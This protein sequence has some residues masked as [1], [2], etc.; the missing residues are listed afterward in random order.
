[1]SRSQT[2]RQIPQE[3]V[4]IIERPVVPA[5]FAS[6]WPRRGQILLGLDLAICLVCFIG[7]Y[8]FRFYLDFPRDQFAFLLVP[9]PPLTPYLKAA[10][11]W[12][13]MW[14]FLLWKD[15]SYR[16][17]L[18]FST[19]LAVQV[20]TVLI[21]GLYA[22][23]FLMAV[24]FMFRQLLLSRLVYVTVF[25]V[26]GLLLILVRV[27]FRAV[28]RSLDEQC[29]TVHRLL[30]VG[31]N[32]NAAALV[33]RLR[34][35]NRC[36]HVIGRLEWEN[37][38]R[39][40]PDDIPILG[41]SSDL[42]R[43]YDQ[44]PFDKL[45]V[46]GGGLPSEDDTASRESLIKALNF[47]EE[48][49]ISYYM[50]PDFL[51]VAVTR[52]EVGSFAGVP[53]V[54]LQDSAL[55]PVYAIF[56][57]VVDVAISLLVLVLGLPFWLA[58]ALLIKLTSKGPVFYAQERMGMYG[59]PFPMYKFRSMVPDADEQL[60]NIIDLDGLAEPVYKIPQDPRVTSIGKFLRRSG[61]DEIPQLV[62]VL[63]GDMSIVGPRPEWVGLAERYEPWE[64]RRLKAKPGITG[65][66]QVMSRGDPSLAKR[67]E[68]DLYYLK[69]QGLFL[70]VF[71]MLK[72][73]LVV[74]R[75]DG[76]D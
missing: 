59:K 14:V 43:I 20:R 76:I 48:K 74:C 69:H 12:A 21:T 71:I 68:L 9:T 38:S 44:T 42:E 75:G 7:A 6:L 54:L 61:L 65:Y 29:F 49:D 58:I 10:V 47:C 51:D 28:A 2:A 63:R 19:Q 55:H 27:G 23:G 11:L 50:I 17:D 18:H 15:Q 5:L 36:T 24:S 62:N 8:Y 40:H 56:K 66:Q 72:T 67:I 16:S 70:D 41:V 46:V 3:Q 25:V 57:R 53:L 31:W 45:L 35:R 34:E 73:I 37:Q 1:V 60:R 33:D 39:T 26:A 32:R 30:L 4:C 52:T 64:R 22:T 13:G